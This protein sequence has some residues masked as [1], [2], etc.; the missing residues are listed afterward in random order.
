MGQS[1]CGI[2]S[3]DFIRIRLQNNMMKN[4]YFLHVDTNLSKLHVD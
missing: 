1:D 3:E 2:L 4:P